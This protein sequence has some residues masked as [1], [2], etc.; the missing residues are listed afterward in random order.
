MIN[1]PALIQIFKRI[2]VEIAR[3]TGQEDVISHTCE[4][5]GGTS[6]D[7][8]RQSCATGRA[9][10]QARCRCQSA[11]LLDGANIYHSQPVARLTA[12]INIAGQRQI[13]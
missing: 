7:F 2:E 12:I 3:A 10:M 13:K 6:Y 9:P 8:I 11:R 1:N 5:A 4:I